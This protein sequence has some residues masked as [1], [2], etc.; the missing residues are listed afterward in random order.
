[1]RTQELTVLAKR[2]QPLP[3]VKMKDGEVYDSVDEPEL[4]YRQLY[5]DLIVNS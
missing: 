4:R 1:M 3:I 2:L 5:V